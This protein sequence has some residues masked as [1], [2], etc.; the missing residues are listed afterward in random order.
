MKKNL[1]VLFPCILLLILGLFFVTDHIALIDNVYNYIVIHNNMATKICKCITFFGSVPCILL[2]CLVLFIF[3]KK[4]KEIYSLYVAILL[5]TA[6]NL[7]IK[8]IVD[9]PRPALIHLVEE[10]TSSFPSGHA[11]ASFTFYG[12]LIYMLWNLECQKKWKILGTVLL[13]ILILFVGY[14][15]IYLNV[16]YVS[17]VLAG[18]FISSIYLW[19]FIK[20]KKKIISK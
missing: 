12:Y 6:I 8:W 20:I 3:C 19:V 5:S 18:F 11:M 15:R 16:H 4:K 14:S 13:S 10:N 7:L 1:I 17:D 9:R 2:I